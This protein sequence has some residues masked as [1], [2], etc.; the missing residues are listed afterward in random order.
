MAY[1]STLVRHTGDREASSV[2]IIIKI[3]NKRN[4]SGQSIYLQKDKYNF[5]QLNYILDIFAQTCHI[6]ITFAILA[7]K[8]IF[9]I[10][11]TFNIFNTLQM[12]QTRSPSSRLCK[13]AIPILCVFRIYWFN[14]ILQKGSH[15]SFH[16]LADV[17]PG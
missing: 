11:H 9:H 3:N 6:Y 8:R 5:G 12:R 17:N 13:Q 10:L 14:F 15:A 16:C 7:P 4:K 2:Y 1:S